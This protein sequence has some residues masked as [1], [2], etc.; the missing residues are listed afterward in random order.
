[1][2]PSIAVR[3]YAAI[4]S[5]TPQNSANTSIP[6]YGH[7]VESTYD[8]WII[9]ID[10]QLGGRKGEGRTDIETNSISLAPNINNT[11]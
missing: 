5:P 6:S 4:C 9:D 2:L 7:T 1:M 11:C 3:V 8:I 10:K